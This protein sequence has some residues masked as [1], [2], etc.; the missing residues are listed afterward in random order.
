MC[1]PCTAWAGWW[2]LCHMHGFEGVWN[3]ITDGCDS[4][5]SFGTYA[6]IM[7]PKAWKRAS[8]VLYTGVHVLG[9]NRQASYQQRQVHVYRKL[10]PKTRVA[11][12]STRLRYT[13]AL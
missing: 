6:R 9:W 4:T 3:H 10:L 11:H 2:Y 5:Q 1:M 13:A 7:K 8:T 12:V